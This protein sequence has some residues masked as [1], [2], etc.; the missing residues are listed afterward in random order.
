MTIYISG[1]LH[2]S[3]ESIAERLG[4]L[5]H[6]CS[7]ED[8]IITLGDVGLE[9]GSK[10]MGSMK[11]TMRAFDGKWIIMRGNH[12]A[13]YWKRHTYIDSDTGILRAENGWEFVDKYGSVLLR[14]K[15]YPN[16]F[17]I[18][19]EGDIL[20]IQNYTCLFI[21]GAYSVDKEY[22][23]K[24]HLP[25]EPE[26]QLTE[27]EFIQLIEKAEEYSEDIDFVFSHT[28]PYKLESELKYLFLGFVNQNNI[29][30]YSEK[31]LDEFADLLEDRNSFKHWFFGHFHD[32]K[33]F[34]E[35]Y[36][37]LFNKVERLEDYV[38]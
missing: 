31:W 23:I 24:E 36:T 12:D 20:G 3:R 4:Q 28:A 37:V 27:K 2:G 9:Y 34:N 13:R 14:Q 7:S 15:K 19:D 8:I 21:P 25:Y 32:T 30:K 22:R 5:P 1:D 29:D 16:I 6:D 35:K 18:K 26:E 33:D 38:K 11:K 10:V 17:Y